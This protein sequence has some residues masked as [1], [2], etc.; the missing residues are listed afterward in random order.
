MAERPQTF[1]RESII[2]AFLF[3]LGEP[4]TPQRVLWVIG[5]DRQAIVLVYGF[6]VGIATAVRNPRAVTGPKD[7]LQRGNQAA[8]WNQY[9]Q[10]L[11][12][13]GMHIGFAVGDNKQSA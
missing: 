8:G 1:I 7:R 13:A 11:A 6:T 4:Y 5:G 2:V 3:F 9:F 10:H 12:V